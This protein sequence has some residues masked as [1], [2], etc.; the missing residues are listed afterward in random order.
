[1]IAQR[2]WGLRGLGA[3]RAVLAV[4]LSPNGGRDMPAAHPAL[5][6]VVRQLSEEYNEDEEDTSP[7][8]FTPAGFMFL[9]LCCC[10][11]CGC[12]ERANRYLGCPE[13]SVCGLS[14]DGDSEWCKSSFSIFFGAVEATKTEVNSR[15]RV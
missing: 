14:A 5:I 15:V 2:E 11:Y 10:F 4:D 13:D 9:V 1:M 12:R 8:L 6:D 3:G 7:D